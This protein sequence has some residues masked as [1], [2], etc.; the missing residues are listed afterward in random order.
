VAFDKR[1]ALGPDFDLPKE[2]RL[3]DYLG[4]PPWTFGGADPVVAEIR[5]DASVAWMV[6]DGLTAEDEWVDEPG[7]GGLLRRRTT[8]R[9]AL[10]RWTLRFGRHAEVIAPPELREGIVETLRAV[11]RMCEE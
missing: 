7:G 3:E 10:L 4:R 11:K 5:F 6:R 8:D 2:F 9:N 1:D